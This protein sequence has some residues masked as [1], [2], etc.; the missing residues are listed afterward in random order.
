MSCTCVCL[1]VRDPEKAIFAQNL[2][3]DLQKNN[4]A[5]DALS[6]F[7]RDHLHQ[8]VAAIVPAQPVDGAALEMSF[9]MAHCWYFEKE[10]TETDA[11][12]LAENIRV[13]LEC[14]PFK[15]LSM[16]NLLLRFSEILI[17]KSN[18]QDLFLEEP[19]CQ[20]VLN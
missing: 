3:Q 4:A 17:A 10:L 1:P 12:L 11:R 14:E 2:D 20:L 19:L 9:P 13:F 15:T 7:I 5:F 8:D 16:H 18:M 6:T